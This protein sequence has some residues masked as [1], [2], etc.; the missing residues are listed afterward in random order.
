MVESFLRRMSI[1]STGRFS[2]ISCYSAV[3]EILSPV[4]LPKEDTS[5]CSR[6]DDYQP[7]FLHVKHDR[8]DILLDCAKQFGE[9]LM[10]IFLS[11]WIYSVE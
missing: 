9:I 3:M 6:V 2:R 1:A 5:A 10:T 4:P 7:T 11:T 8:T